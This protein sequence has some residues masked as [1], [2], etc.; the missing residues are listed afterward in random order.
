MEKRIVD[1]YINY[2]QDEYY[3][4]RC[5]EC[6]IVPTFYITINYHKTHSRFFCIKHIFQELKCRIMPLF[7]IDIPQELRLIIYDFM[8]CEEFVEFNQYHY[9]ESTVENREYFSYQEYLNR[10]VLKNI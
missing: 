7:T 3:I 9:I 8:F 2:D 1:L 6:Y 10:Y 5:K 4:H